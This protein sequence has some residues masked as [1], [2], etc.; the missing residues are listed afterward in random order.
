[1]ITNKLFDKIII[2]EDKD[3]VN[4]YALKGAKVAK[5]YIDMSGDEKKAYNNT[6]LKTFEENYEK[7]KKEIE[8][9]QAAKNNQRQQGNIIK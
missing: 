2:G 5:K 1:M 7:I 4:E 8:Q 6:V 9:E 3:L